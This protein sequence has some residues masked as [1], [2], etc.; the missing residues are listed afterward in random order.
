M[1]CL[2]LPALLLCAACA[3][4]APIPVTYVPQ[5]ATPAAAGTPEEQAARRLDRALGQDARRDRARDADP[6]AASA[7]GTP[8][9]GTNLEIGGGDAPQ[10]T[11]QIGIPFR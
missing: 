2:L 4:E 6:Y 7:A 1:R 10:A 8:T 9:P 11:P 3:Q 5:P